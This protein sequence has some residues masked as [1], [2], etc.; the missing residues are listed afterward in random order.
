MNILLPGF[1]AL[2]PLTEEWKVHST[3]YIEEHNDTGWASGDLGLHASS[4]CKPG[5]MAEQ[6]GRM[7]IG[8]NSQEMHVVTCPLSSFRQWELD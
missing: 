5:G 2:A 1:T 7:K 8:K 6:Q 3:L 4:D